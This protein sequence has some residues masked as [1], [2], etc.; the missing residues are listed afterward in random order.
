M[1]VALYRDFQQAF[2]VKLT[3]RRHFV[4]H[5]E[6]SMDVRT[7]IRWFLH[8]F[9]IGGIV[10]VALILF[11]ATLTLLWQ[12]QPEESANVQPSTAVINIIAA[13]TDTPVLPTPTVTPIPTTTLDVPPP[14]EQG[15]ISVG[16]YVKI[17]GTGGDGLRVRTDPGLESETRLVGAEDEVF[18]VTEG[19]QEVDG[20]T[21][22]F[23]VGP[24]DETRR[25]WVVANYLAV[26]QGP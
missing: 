10:L 13:P 23:I 26:V 5:E 18:Q 4:P 9:V 2:F 15:S 7:L 16:A 14:P 22:W 8:P 6:A 12:S 20:Y 21:W 1:R 25:G 3:A 19:P 24:Y 17:T 11:M